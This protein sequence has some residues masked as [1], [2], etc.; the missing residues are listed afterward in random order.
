MAKHCRCFFENLS[1]KERATTTAAAATAEEF[2]QSI[3]APSSTHPGT[4]YPVRA[5]PHSDIYIY[6]YI[7]IW[8]CAGNPSSLL[9]SMD[10]LQDC[11]RQELAR[12]LHG[13]CME[14]MIKREEV[15]KVSRN[16]CG[17]NTERTGTYAQH[18]ELS[19]CAKGLPGTCGNV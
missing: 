7:Y 15:A 2:S 1:K 9:W 17:T 6:I 4:T 8:A 14:G 13:T 5:I 10:S 3:Q 16:V 11:F 18:T 12:G 19:T